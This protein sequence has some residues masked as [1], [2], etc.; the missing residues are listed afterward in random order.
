M[1]FIMDLPMVL[2]KNILFVFVDKFSKFC[3]LIPIFV[4]EGELSSK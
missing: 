2:G 4:G 3:W 1:D